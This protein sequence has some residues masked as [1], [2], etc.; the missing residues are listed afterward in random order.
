MAS[1][2]STINLIYAGENPCNATM[3]S[4]VNAKAWHGS[5]G[6]MRPAIGQ[7]LFGL[8]NLLLASK[9]ER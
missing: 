5:W 9:T 7:C 4:A 6:R 8:E 2:S 1:A 3:P